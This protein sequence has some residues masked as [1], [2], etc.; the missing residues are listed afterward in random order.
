MYS[1]SRKEFINPDMEMV[2][3]IID[4][5]NEKFDPTETNRVSVASWTCIS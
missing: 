1:I 4:K 5:L 2:G 3:R